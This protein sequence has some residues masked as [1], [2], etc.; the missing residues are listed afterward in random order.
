[1]LDEELKQRIS[2][3]VDDRLDNADAMRLMNAL[4]SDRE[5]ASAYSRYLLIG[6]SIRSRTKVMGDM[7]FVDRVHRALDDEP[8]VLVPLWK[9]PVKDRLVSV[10]LAATLAGMA[11]IVG[12]SVVRQ[13]NLTVS[14]AGQQ[15]RFVESTAMPSSLQSYLINHNGTAYLAANGGLLPY[16]RVVSSG[17]QK[18]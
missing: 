3:L 1:M 5:T 11:V 6:Q 4:E 12:E 15:A 13:S 7:A 2:L 14:G 9:R 10:A 18:R 16:L 8:V 17:I